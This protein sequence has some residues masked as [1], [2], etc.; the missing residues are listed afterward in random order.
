MDFVDE[1]DGI[2]RAEEV[3]AFGLCD[4]LSHLLDATRH[5]TEGEK[6]R[7]E[8]QGYDFG[9]CGF[10]HPRRSPPDKRRGV[11]V[12]CSGRG[13]WDVGVRREVS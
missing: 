8:L 3:L 5:G 1:E 10:A 7:I 6:R 11:A 12:R 2:A 4:D 9:E 13:S